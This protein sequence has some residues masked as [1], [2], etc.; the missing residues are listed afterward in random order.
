MSLIQKFRAWSK[1]FWYEWFVEPQPED[2]EPRRRRGRR[3]RLHEC[4]H[5]RYLD[6]CPVCGNERLDDT[7]GLWND[8]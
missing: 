8:Y 1:R 4:R 2:N 3:R 7:T 5:G 6:A